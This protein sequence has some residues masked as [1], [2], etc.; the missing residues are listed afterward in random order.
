MKSV[1]TSDF[2][3]EN[4]P[5]FGKVR[6]CV[7]DNASELR[8]E[9]M[10]FVKVVHNKNTGGSGGF[11]RGITELKK[12]E[13][14]SHMVF[15]DDDVEFL[16]ETFYRL[17]AF[18]SYLTEELED[19][20]VAG[21][22][23]RMDERRIQYTAAEKWNSGEISHVG[24]QKDMT[25]KENLKRINDSCDAEYTGWWLGCF[26]MKF[27]RNNMPLPFFLHCDDVEYGLRHGGIPVILNGIQVWH[28]TYEYRQN[29]VITYYD[30]RNRYIVN[31]LYDLWRDKAEPVEQWKEWITKAHL[32][33]DY[34]KEYMLIQAFLDYT[35]GV[36]WLKK[37]DSGRYHKWLLK[38]KANRVK[39]ALLWRVAEVKYQYKLYEK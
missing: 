13:G 28:E 39:T 3:D 14:I 33:E 5:L 29:R 2:F 25:L 34:Q 20:V 35:K 37:I 9:N 4:S 30:L 10:T 26:S 22:M 31:D 8:D 27:V 12:E 18:L 7:V 38:S 15:M 6:I 32:K 1:I 36:K 16:M 19:M 24:F 23:F 11:T 21:R 17:Y